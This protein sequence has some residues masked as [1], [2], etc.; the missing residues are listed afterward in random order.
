M[1][2]SVYLRG[3]ATDRI[4]VVSVVG[5]SRSGK[6]TFVE[7]LIRELKARR[8]RLAV[9]KHHYH[10]DLEF[11]VPG[12]DSYRFAHAGADHV[13]LAGPTKVVHVRQLAEELSL[14]DV[15]AGIYGVDLIVTEGYKRAT[16]PKIEVARRVC[17][18]KPAVVGALSDLVAPI[19]RLIAIVSDMRF[20]LPVPQFALEDAP[21]VADFLEKQLL[22]C[23]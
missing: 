16:T 1:D 15:V 3:G 14:R 22:H 6:T 23:G 11:D 8:Y 12:K 13:I 5:R 4:P 2:D 18:G 7:K 19:D 20:D 21:G 17:S 10:A 9:I